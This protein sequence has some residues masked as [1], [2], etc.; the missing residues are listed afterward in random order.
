MSRYVMMKSTA[1]LSLWACK[2][3]DTAEIAKTLHMRESDVERIIHADR[4]SR[5]RAA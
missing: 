3:Y 4:E 5:R 2:I 1:V